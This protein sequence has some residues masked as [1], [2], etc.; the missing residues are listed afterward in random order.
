LHKLKSGPLIKKLEQQP[1]KTDLWIDGGHNEAAGKAV[2]SFLKTPFHGKSHLVFG[3]LNSKDVRTFLSEMTN[4]LDS[5]ICVTVPGDVPSLTGKQVAQN[6][7]LIQKKSSVAKNIEQ[8]VDKI[9]IQN[10]T[11][12]NLRIVICGSLYLCG[13]ILS[14][15]T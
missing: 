5:I 1:F 3:M 8:A 12:S 7:K 6:A 11:S 13:H 14:N 10:K 9:I 4:M 2:A 15:H